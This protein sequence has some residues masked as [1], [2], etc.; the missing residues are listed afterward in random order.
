ML[1]AH[2]VDK[3]N[4]REIRRKKVNDALAINSLGG[5]EPSDFAKELLEKYVE[6]ELKAEEVTE[7]VIEKYK[8]K[9]ENR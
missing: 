5:T 2:G 7:K 9:Y 4:K 8:A 3:M 6:G 1:T